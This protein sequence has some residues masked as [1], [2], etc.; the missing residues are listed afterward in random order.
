MPVR[1]QRNVPRVKASAPSTA[2]APSLI[3]AWRDPK[4]LKRWWKYWVTDPLVG[5]GE[6]AVYYLF[7]VLPVGVCSAIGA[8]RGRYIGQDRQRVERQ[9]REALKLVAPELA[10]SETDALLHTLH[11]NSGRALLETLVMDRIWDGGHVRVCPDHQTDKLRSDP[12]S[13]IF[14]SVHLGNLGDLQGMC[15]MRLTGSRGMTVTRT[16]PNRFR[17]RLSEKLREKHGADVLQP[18]LDAT[19]QLI[20]HLRA[21][22]N[23]VLIHLDEARGR[24]IYFPTFGRTLPYGS[25][26]SIAIRLSAITGAPLIPIY[27]HR[28]D[29]ADFDLHIYDEL[30]IPDRHDETQHL[31]MARQLDHMFAEHIRRDLHDWQQLYFLRPEN[32]PEYANAKSI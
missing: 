8:L 29:G 4:A 22:G 13:K 7:R 24:Q 2:A 9:A 16:Q 10:P 26:L 11:R 5:A 32:P 27:M 1:R 20:T 17:Q 14:V 19:R 6:F 31:V 30:P 23:V 21:P 25:N 12:R 18:G 15:L 28:R 3:T